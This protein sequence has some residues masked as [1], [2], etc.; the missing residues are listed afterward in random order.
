MKT[1][2]INILIDVDH[3]ISNA[4]W[5]DP[6]IGTV[7][8]DEYHASSKRDHPIYDI[9]LMLRALYAAKVYNFVGFTARPEKWRKLTIEKMIE[10]D[11][12]LDELLMRPDEDYHPAPELKLAL[13]RK[14]F[15]ASFPEQIAFILDDREDVILAFKALGVTA[16][17]V[18]ASRR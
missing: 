1:T 16:L 13:V 17:Q 7:T 15:G 10:F 6:M 14:R 4:F 9:V 2:R 12:P 5:R 11:A 3:V 18:H 8:W